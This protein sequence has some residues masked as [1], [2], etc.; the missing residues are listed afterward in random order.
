MRARI[1]NLEDKFRAALLAG[2]PNGLWIETPGRLDTPCWLWAHEHWLTTAD[3]YG[4]L[5]VNGKQVGAH[6]FAY[7]TVNGPLGELCAL[8]RCDVRQCV[9]PSHLL[10]GTKHDN[11]LDASAKGRLLTGET[12]QKSHG[13]TLPRAASWRAAHAHQVKLSD[14]Q[15]R[16]IRERRKAGETGR[17]LATEFGISE[18]MVSSILSGKRRKIVL[19]AH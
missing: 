7:E 14:G 18:S 12:W 16:A 13:G 5:C 4:Y 11:I 3:T 6:R 19:Q 1:K 15:V 9:R 17:A 10:P 8:H 2:E